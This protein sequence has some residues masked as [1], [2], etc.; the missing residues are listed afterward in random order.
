MYFCTIMNKFS[1]LKRIGNVSLIFLL[2]YFSVHIL[3]LLFTFIFAY[4]IDLPDIKF[5]FAYIDYNVEAY[6]DWTR[7]RI[8]LLYGL[9][10]FM[11][12]VSAIVLWVIMK[13]FSFKYKAKIKLYLLWSIITC[14][15]F[16]IGNFITAPFNAYGIAVVASWYY[17]KKEVLFIVS[18]LFWIAIPAIAWYYS[19]TF[20]RSAYSRNFIRTKW[21]RVEFIGETF[22]LPFVLVSFLMAFILVIY[23]GYTVKYYFAIDF[24]RAF[25]LLAI[26]IFIM[27]FNFN[28][29]YIDISRNKELERIDYT[30]LFVSLSSLLVIYI[31]LFIV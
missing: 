19:K 14:L 30:L 15:V 16:V 7:L 25:L 21:T 28:K 31:S 8:V 9:P 23:P 11:M 3:Y 2:S 17:I 1:S 24:I 26:L 22:L 20:M 13:K 5:H 4:L 6:A 10:N 27:I 18:T 29:R 12:L